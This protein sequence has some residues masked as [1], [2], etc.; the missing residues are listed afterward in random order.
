MRIDLIGSGRESIRID[1][2]R[3]E[4]NKY[5]GPTDNTIII[6]LNEDVAIGYCSKTKY[7]LNSI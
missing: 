5:A 1:S 4:S 7:L 3:S 6:R 2:N